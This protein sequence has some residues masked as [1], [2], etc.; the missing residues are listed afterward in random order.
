MAFNEIDI[1]ESL[2]DL[3]IGSVKIGSLT[4]SWDLSDLLRAREIEDRNNGAFAVRGRLIMPACGI[5]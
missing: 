5:Y 3:A 1:A 4:L 2:K